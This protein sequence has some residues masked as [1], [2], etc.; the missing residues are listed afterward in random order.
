MQTQPN[1]LGRATLIS[2]RSGLKRGKCFC[3]EINKVAVNG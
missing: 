3:K 2:D 1:K